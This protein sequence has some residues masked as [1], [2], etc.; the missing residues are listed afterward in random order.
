M[1]TFVSFGLIIVIIQLLL[2]GSINAWA[3]SHRYDSGILASITDKEIVMSGKA[4]KIL[5]NTKVIFKIKDAK[6]AYYEH[7]GRLSSLRIGEK[8]F[9][10]ATGYDIIEV[11]VL[12]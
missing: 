12:R 9:L 5:S 3:T 11:E 7:K 8:I 2:A 4:Y 10:K 6:G 1:R